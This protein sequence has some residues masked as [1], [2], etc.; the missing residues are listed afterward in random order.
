MLPF[1]KARSIVRK[2]RLKSATEWKEY[3]RS[4]RRP[5]NIP[6]H[7]ELS[8]K[9]KGWISYPDWM[10][11]HYCATVRERPKPA[12]MPFKE[13]RELVRA[14]RLRSL[15]EWEEWSSGDQRP[16][17]C[18]IP[19]CPD[20][21]YKD[22][23]WIS[24]SDWMGY[25]GRGS[26]MLPFKEAR[27]IVR[28]LNLG[29]VQEWYTWS[30]S[31]LRPRNIPAAPAQTYEGK[32][33]TSMPDWMGYHFKRGDQRKKNFKR[34]RLEETEPST[35]TASSS[36]AVSSVRS[37]S[38]L[39]HFSAPDSDDETSSVSFVDGLQIHE[40]SIGFLL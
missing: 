21:A 19:D 14:L 22:K 15:K 7:P 26:A 12:L 20:L 11:Y 32:G 33:W 40:N 3:C 8:Y 6:S 10:G 23:G 34:K 24:W 16:P 18:N 2:L 9:D 28:A 4:G 13:A 38:H 17:G 5:S 36:T 30:K 39:S 1:T 29:S 37:S 31:G 27:E 25:A 35:T